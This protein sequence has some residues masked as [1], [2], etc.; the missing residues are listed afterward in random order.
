ANGVRL[1]RIEPISPTLEDLYFAV[2][3]KR[4]AGEIAEDGGRR[5]A[6]G[7]RTGDD[8]REPAAVTDRNRQVAALTGWPG[9]EG[10]R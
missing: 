4:V 1:T 9:S 8:D 7:D 10:S 2:R 6:D 3:T 5:L